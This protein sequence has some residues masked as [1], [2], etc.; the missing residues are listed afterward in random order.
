MATESFERAARERQYG[1]YDLSVYVPQENWGPIQGTRSFAINTFPLSLRVACFD[2][3]YN[4]HR[5]KE[6]G[7][8]PQYFDFRI[9]YPFASKEVVSELLKGWG[10]EDQ[11]CIDEIAQGHKLTSS[12]VHLMDVVTDWVGFIPA[13]P[14][15]TKSLS[16]PGKAI[17]VSA[18]LDNSAY[19]VYLANPYFGRALP[20]DLVRFYDKRL[21]DS[22]GT[23]KWDEYDIHPQVF[24]DVMDRDHGTIPTGF[25]FP[26]WATLDL[27]QLLDPK[28]Q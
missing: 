5:A 8:T 4:A 9:P 11:E 2:L 17:V 13:D 1:P 26:Q 20:H 19:T 7:H 21:S 27:T 23:G 6:K 28:N 10:S 24:D 12:G 15:S 25:K 22:A 3:A 14:E 18:A 16:V